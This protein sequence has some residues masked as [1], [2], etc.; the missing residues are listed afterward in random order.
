MPPKTPPYSAMVE[1]TVVKQEVNKNRNK[2]VLNLTENILPSYI[3]EKF[4]T[5]L[6]KCCT[7]MHKEKVICCIVFLTVPILFILFLLQVVTLFRKINI[8]NTNYVPC[9]V[10]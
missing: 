6:M 9:F 1:F 4:T 7:C 2:Q 8:I 5:R 10:H 3:K